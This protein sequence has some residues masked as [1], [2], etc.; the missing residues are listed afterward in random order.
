MTKYAARLRTKFGEIIINFDTTQQLKAD[1]GGIDFKAIVALL[2]EKFRG[3]IAEETRQPKPSYEDIYRFTSDGLVELLKIP[4]SEPATIGLILFAYDPYPIS[5]QQISLLS[6]VKD[7]ARKYL[8]QKRYK[9]F[10]ERTADKNY[11]L[12]Y[13]GKKWILREVIP[14]LRKKKP[15]S[16]G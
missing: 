8:T 2:E 7:A 11:G 15:E 4:D 9:K 16:S 3:V 6:G 14:R 5:T 13:D 10:F 12:S 1:L